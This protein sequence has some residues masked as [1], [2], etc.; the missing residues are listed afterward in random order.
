MAVD[1]PHPLYTLKQP[2]WTQMSHTYGGEPSVKAQGT[3]YLPATQGMILDGMGTGQR[4][5]ADYDAYLT[6]SV[7]HNFL[8]EGVE[9]MVG[10]MH[11]EPARIEVP[12][13]MLPLL[14]KIT[15]DGE[16]PWMLLRK[17]NE[18]QI[19]YGRCGLLVEAPT[20]Q[21]V[22]KALPYLALYAAPAITNWDVGIREQGQNRIEFVTLNESAFER[23][24]DFQWDFVNRF[25][26]L[27]MSQTAASLSG[28]KQDASTAGGV[29][30]VNAL[31]ANELT[32]NSER[33]VTPSIG[34]VTLDEVPFM[35]VGA[36]GLSPDPEDI[37]GL[38]LS[39]LCL[40]IFRGEADYRQTLFLQSQ[41]TLVTVGADL[42]P[43]QRTGA[44]ARIDLPRDSD[45]KYIGVSANGLSAMRV[46]LEDD[47]MAA[48]E[49]ASRLL[50]TGGA[51]A[52]YQSGSG[53]RI[54]LSPKTATLKTVAETGADALRW[55]LK[56]IARWIG[57]D[58][59]KVV[60]EANTEFVEAE[61]ASRT[62]LEL[63][64]AKSLGA[65]LSNA[66]IHRFIRKQDLSEMDFKDELAEIKKE[67]PILPPALTQPGVSG[68][69]SGGLG[70]AT[71]G[72]RV[73][74]GVDKGTAE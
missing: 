38:E 4:G 72:N 63:T 44:G 3:T 30:Q 31:G 45:A 69:A 39:N 68:Q 10:I 22:D 17:M 67:E 6:R 40:A 8:K 60:V 29:Y 43:E 21:L 12:D 70:R 16:N 28:I 9:T 15:V 50:E 24:A 23:K 62:L 73:P 59:T 13:R 51:G 57:E 37:P 1:S 2:Q 74:R 53:L 48:K 5:L 65:P 11:L 34:G 56:L 66:S 25:R 49:K 14:D 32:I 35:F 26:V 46:A 36:K 27:A 71:G 58:E 55:A 7:Y 33:W 64:Q 18:W 52:S 19:L 61:V 42:D 54:R 41:E 20:G 47:K